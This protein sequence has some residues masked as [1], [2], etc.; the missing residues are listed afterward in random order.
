MHYDG[1]WDEF[2]EKDIEKQNRADQNRK[3]L[4]ALPTDEMVKIMF[5]GYLDKMNYC[6]ISDLA[7]RLKKEGI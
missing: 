3:K 2:Y 4:E 7:D 1:I 6:D 5:K